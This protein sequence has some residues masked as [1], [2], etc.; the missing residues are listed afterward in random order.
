MARSSTGSSPPRDLLFALRSIPANI[1]RSI[2]ISICKKR[3]FGPAAAGPK[4]SLQSAEE[5]AAAFRPRKPLVEEVAELVALVLRQHL[6]G[7]RRGG[8]GVLLHRIL[9]RALLV[10]DGLRGGKV[11]RGLDQR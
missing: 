4:V 6:Q 7:L 5:S 3:Q 8:Q 9:G 1:R 11:V 2:A 10:D